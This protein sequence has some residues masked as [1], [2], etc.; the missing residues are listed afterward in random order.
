MQVSLFFSGIGFGQ[1]RKQPTGRRLLTF[2][3]LGQ[4]L[5]GWGPDRTAWPLP[6]KRSE[7]APSVRKRSGTL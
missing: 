3:D 6:G 4:L 7:N 2:V 1:E 5:G